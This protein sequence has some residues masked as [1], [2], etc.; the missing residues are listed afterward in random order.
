MPETQQIARTTEDNEVGIRNCMKG[1]PPELLRTAKTRSSRYYCGPG[2]S[3]RSR[4]GF[5]SMQ[6]D[7]GAGRCRSS[8]DR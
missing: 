7:G 1:P 4:T 8:K 6:R 2:C 3:S 5:S